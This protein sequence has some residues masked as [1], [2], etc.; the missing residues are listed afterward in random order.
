MTDN[1]R[2]EA[3]KAL[4][5]LNDIDTHMSDILELAHKNGVTELSKFKFKHQI[6]KIRTYISAPDTRKD[7]AIRDLAAVLAS[8]ARREDNILIQPHEKAEQ[9]LAKHADLIEGE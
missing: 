6:N 4:E 3:L 8:I 2:E 5:A 9:V 7:D 1:P